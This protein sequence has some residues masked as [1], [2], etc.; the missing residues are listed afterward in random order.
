M[1]SSVILLPGILSTVDLIP[2]FIPPSAPITTGSV[3]V[4]IIQILLTSFSKSLYFDNFSTSF[5]ETFLSEGIRHINQL[6]CVVDVIFNN[7]VW[8]I[9]LYFL[10]RVHLHIPNYYYYY[11]Y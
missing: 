9:C 4:F 1:R 5:V 11:Y 6:A 10:T 2:F 8:L 7:N 3:V